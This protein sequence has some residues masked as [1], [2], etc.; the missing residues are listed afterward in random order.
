MATEKTTSVASDDPEMATA[1][2]EAKNS[3]GLFFDA[4]DNPSKEQESFLVKIAFDVGDSYEHI[5]LADPDFSGKK[6][7]GVVAN[8]PKTNLLRFKQLIE[9]DSMYISDW[10]YIDAGLVVGAFTTRILRDRM[11]HEERE[12]FDETTSFKE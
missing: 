8:K 5:W 10:M 4:L 12:A 1:I 6:P 11:T 3:I 9:F 2:R 7:M